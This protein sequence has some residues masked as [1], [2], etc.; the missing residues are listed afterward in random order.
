MTAKPFILPDGSEFISTGET[1]P[2]LIRR[3]AEPE[4]IATSICFLLSDDGKFV[5]KAMWD[6][7][8]GFMESNFTA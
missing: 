5:T 3:L 1:L 7:D 4:E 2:Q 6:I 8:G